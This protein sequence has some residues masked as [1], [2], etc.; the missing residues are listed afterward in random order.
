M[1]YYSCK[2]E[3]EVVGNKSL[4]NYVLIY[5]Y[6]KIDNYKLEVIFLKY[7]KGKSIEY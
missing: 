1:N 6:K 5:I 3:V 2:V 4:Y 7:L